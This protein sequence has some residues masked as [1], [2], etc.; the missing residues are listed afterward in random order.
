MSLGFFTFITQ[1]PGVGQGYYS[2]VDPPGVSGLVTV[3]VDSLTGPAR[4]VVTRYNGLPPFE[5]E[6]ISGQEYGISLSQIQ[7]VGILNLS[8]AVLTGTFSISI[9]E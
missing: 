1:D 9:P 7:T 3:S 5:I 4:V 2:A 6:L 8:D